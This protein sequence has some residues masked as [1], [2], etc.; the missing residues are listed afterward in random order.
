MANQPKKW[1]KLI[2]VIFFDKNQKIEKK[3]GGKYSINVV[4]NFFET[5]IT[6]SFQI[7]LTFGPMRSRWKNMARNVT[8]FSQIFTT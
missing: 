2:K 6:Y 8:R 3:S 1:L 4:N 5:Q 7:G